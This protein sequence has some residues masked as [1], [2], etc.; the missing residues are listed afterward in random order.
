MYSYSAKIPIKNQLDKWRRKEN[1]DRH[2]SL[3]GLM[4]LQGEDMKKETKIDVKHIEEEFQFQTSK[5]PQEYWKQL[6]SSKTRTNEQEHI[7]FLIDLYI[8]ILF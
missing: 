1:T 5:S 4:C 6:G 8:I 2:T 7:L 3:L